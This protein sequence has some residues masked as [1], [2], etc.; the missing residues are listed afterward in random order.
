MK[1]FSLPNLATQSPRSASLGHDDDLRREHRAF[2]DA[3]CESQKRLRHR[4][5]LQ[6]SLSSMSSARRILA[7]MMAR[8]A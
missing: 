8:A 4:R 3:K 7:S 5:F 6:S 2:D 1:I